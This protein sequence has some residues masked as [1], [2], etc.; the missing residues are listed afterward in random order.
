MFII[1]T[2]PDTLPTLD[3]QN[4]TK[5]IKLYIYNYIYI[6]YC[7]VYGMLCQFCLN[8]CFF[9][10]LTFLWEHTWE[11][12]ERFVR[13]IIC[14]NPCLFFVRTHRLLE[15]KFV[16]TPLMWM[17]HWFLTHSLLKQKRWLCV[18]TCV[19]LWRFVSCLG[20]C[21]GYCFI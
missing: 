18:R 2:L 1:I 8:M 13:I 11:S 9:C 7:T 21:M 20:E 6:S 12:C 16:R 4:Y 19:S 15:H 3:V 14:E 5:E 10:E 17:S